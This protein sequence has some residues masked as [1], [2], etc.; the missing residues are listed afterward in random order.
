ML[1]ACFRELQTT[2]S[3]TTSL[4]ADA[5]IFSYFHN[6]SHSV[7]FVLDIIFVEKKA[8]NISAYLQS[9]S[10]QLLDAQI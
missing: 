2:D 6:S 5:R 4:R 7:L 10:G 3:R 8:L 9:G 1:T